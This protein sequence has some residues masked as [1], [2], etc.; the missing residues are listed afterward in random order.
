MINFT[1]KIRF[2]NFLF[3][4]YYPIYK[5]I[6]KYIGRKSFI[7]P[8]IQLIGA[9]YVSIGVNSRISR[10]SRIIAINAYAGHKYSPEI[11]I[12]DNVNIGFCCTIS[13]INK[14]IISND[15][16]FGDLVYISDSKHGYDLPRASILGKPLI[17][18]Q[19]KIGR[20]AWIGYG[21]FI[22][23]EIEI[24]EFSIVA[25]NSVVTKSVQD[26]T[27]VGGIPAKPIKKYNLQTKSWDKI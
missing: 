3:L 18:G 12:G 5:I 20:G 27:I 22:A 10:N 6:F 17:R 16:T 24:G 23:G 15:V 8:F 11:I 14:V 4:L 13:A 7:S 26:Y 1:K 19:I 2:E 21:S 25:A 9:K